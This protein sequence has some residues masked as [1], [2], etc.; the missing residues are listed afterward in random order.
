MEGEIKIKEF[1]IRYIGTNTFDNETIIKTLLDNDYDD[2]GLLLVDEVTPT[3]EKCSACNGLG[4]VDEAVGFELD[5]KFCN[6]SGMVDI[7]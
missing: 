1:R 4:N 3:I 2:G 6:G 7:K 5:C